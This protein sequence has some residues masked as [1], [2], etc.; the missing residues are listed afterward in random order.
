ML[1]SPSH[2]DNVT[3]QLPGCLK[4]PSIN[5]VFVCIQAFV[6]S[7][8]LLCFKTG[9]EYQVMVQV[10]I[11]ACTCKKFR[12][13]HGY[14]NRDIYVVIELVQLAYRSLRLNK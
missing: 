12:K 8:F 1:N 3:I 6:I 9:S 7:H 5:E 10:R 4:D 13:G 2:K 11:P 14:M